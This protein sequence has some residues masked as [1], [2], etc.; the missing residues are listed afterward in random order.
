MPNSSIAALAGATTFVPPLP[1]TIMKPH[2]PG[3]LCAVR[4]EQVAR[5]LDPPKPVN[6][7]TVDS[8]PQVVGCWFRGHRDRLERALRTL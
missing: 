1:A 5:S 2:M 8:S 6:C 4:D 3:L 7:R